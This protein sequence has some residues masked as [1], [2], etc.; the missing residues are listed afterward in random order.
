MQQQEI[1][2]TVDVRVIVENIYNNMRAGHELGMCDL[3]AIDKICRKID[4]NKKLSIFYEAGLSKA[5][6]EEIVSLENMAAMADRFLSIALYLFNRAK[7]E[8]A[9]KLVNT[10]LNIKTV[11]TSNGYGMQFEKLDARICRL[12]DIILG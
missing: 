8:M 5:A 1:N 9:L 6:S 3:G 2:R 12:L 7:I 4:I 11:L 10:S